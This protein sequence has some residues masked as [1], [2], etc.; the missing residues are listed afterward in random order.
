MNGRY[1]EDPMDRQLCGW[2]RLLTHV[3]QLVVTFGQ[4]WD[5]A[6]TLHARNHP[7][8]PK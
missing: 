8:L 7:H 5:V 2:G 3:D 4:P 1:R 6:D